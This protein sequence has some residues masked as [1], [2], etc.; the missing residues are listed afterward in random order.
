MQGSTT[1]YIRQS[2][3]PKKD[4]VTWSQPLEKLI[5]EGHLEPGSTE[6]KRQTNLNAA[7]NALS[8]IN[9]LISEKQR[10]WD[11]AWSAYQTQL[12]LLRLDVEEA[13]NELNSLTAKQNRLQQLAEKEVASVSAVA[14]GKIRLQRAEQ[15]LKLYADIE[16]REPELNPTFDSLD[17]KPAVN[18]TTDSA[19]PT[20]EST[21]GETPEK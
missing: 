5:S 18:T 6:E 10:D 16:A 21:S 19:V 4:V 15:V 1:R 14:S 3:R 17:K 8:Q 9:S 2:E 12:Q 11:Y 13:T 7:Q 20:T